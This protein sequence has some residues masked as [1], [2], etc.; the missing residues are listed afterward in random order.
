MFILQGSFRYICFG[1]EVGDRGTHHI[2][3]YVYFDD[4]KVLSVVKRKLLPKAHLEIS[5]GSLQQNIDYTSK[6]GHWYEIGVRPQPGCAQWD[7]IEQVMADPKSNPHLYQQYNKMYRSLTL[8][9]K[10]T[11]DRRL[12]LIE[13]SQIFRYADQSDMYDNETLDCYNGERLCLIEFQYMDDFD[14]LRWCQCRPKKFRRGYEV[15]CFDPEVIY[16]ST[17]TPHQYS[18]AFKIF[19]E[20]IEK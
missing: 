9:N 16:L 10:R 8:S 12:I 19:H 13:S 5:K 11:H 6:D 17:H 3:G 20:Y 7:R 1:F 18:L 4:A 2:Q 15:I 14:I